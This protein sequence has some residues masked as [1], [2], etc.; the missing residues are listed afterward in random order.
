M[1]ATTH[2]VLIRQ[3]AETRLQKLSC[4]EL[5]YNEAWLQSLLARHPELLPVSEIEPAFERLVCAGREIACSHG[6]IDNLYLTAGGD[7]VLVETKLHANPQARREVVAQALDYVAALT[8]M[9]YESFQAAVCAGLHEGKRPHSLYDLVRD[10]PE[11]L[12]E[13][14]FCDAVSANL[15]RGRM[16][17]LVVG[18]GVRRE[19]ESLAGVLQQHA[20][21]HFTF[22]LVELAVYRA[23]NSDLFVVP[24]ILA[25]TVMI[26]RG[27][28]RIADAAHGKVVIEPTPVAGSSLE[29]S[30]AR[31]LT[32]IEFD[33]KM[34]AR[35]PGLAD[36]I[37]RFAASLESLGVYVEMK[38]SL[39]L[40]AE[41]GGKK[42]VNLGYI[43]TN[44]QLWVASWSAAPVD[45][46]LN[47]LAM[48]TG[49]QVGTFRGNDPTLYLQVKGTTSA[50]RIEAYLPDHAEGWRNAIAALLKQLRESD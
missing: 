15:M 5:G 48:M 20:G 23:D 29:A 13:V 12:T 9:S 10:Q 18:D 31:D 38:G 8:A 27:I 33:E 1:R 17:V 6:Y 50:P 37:W 19:T 22:A 4:G 24:S 30:K 28:V 36:D 35:R 7:I 11:V 45:Q 34:N 16:I 39:N 26:E 42:P 47:S 43:Q 2:P 46:Y 3:N 14:D 32:R 21:S 49:G 41:I 40:K 25:K 44:G